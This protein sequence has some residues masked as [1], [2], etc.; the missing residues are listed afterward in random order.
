MMEGLWTL[1]EKGPM[2]GISLGLSQL[3]VDLLPLGRAKL[4]AK[5]LS[6]IYVPKLKVD[7]RC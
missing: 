2:Q 7:C 3:V 4:T 5:I 1:D 6:L